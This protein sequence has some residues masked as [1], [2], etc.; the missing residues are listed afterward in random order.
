MAVEGR[1]GH[2]I[3][4]GMRPRDPAGNRREVPLQ[5]QAKGQEV[6]DDHNPLNALLDQPGDGA[7]QIGLAQFQKCGFHPREAASPRQFRR[8]ETNCLIRRFHSRSVG[9]DY[10]PGA[11]GCGLGLAARYAATRRSRSS[12]T[13][14][15]ASRVSTLESAIRIVS[16]VQMSVAVRI[17]LLRDR[18]T[19]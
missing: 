16:T 6:R 3:Y 8:D 2:Q 10:Y 12:S 11:H 1:S 17:S 5:V 19:G 14:L 9:K 18:A 4:A 7:V 15:S 13:L